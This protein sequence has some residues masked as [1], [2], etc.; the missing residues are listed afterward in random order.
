MGF[1]FSF[2]HSYLLDCGWNKIQYLVGCGSLLLY[3]ALLTRT[4]SMFSQSQVLLLISIASYFSLSFCL[5]RRLL[6]VWSAVS[7]LLF[8]L[9]HLLHKEVFH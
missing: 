9:L 8:L 2:I 3:S 7:D 6:A 4:H 5:S 1:N